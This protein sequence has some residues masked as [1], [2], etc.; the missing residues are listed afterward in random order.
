[1]RNLDFIKR[2]RKKV[3]TVEVTNGVRKGNMGR[4]RHERKLLPRGQERN[5]F[6]RPEKQVVTRRQWKKVDTGR[7]G[8][9]VLT[10]R[11]AD[12]TKDQLK[13]AEGQER[14]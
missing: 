14:K 6:R 8:K 2:S 11:E 7:P 5:V 1:M 13:I 10:R 9:K 3:C 4:D 12:K